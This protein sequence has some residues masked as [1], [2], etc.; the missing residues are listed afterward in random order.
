VGLLKPKASKYT[1]PEPAD[2]YLMNPLLIPTC[3]SITFLI[4]TC[5]SVTFLI[6]TCRTYL[7]NPFLS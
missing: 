4:P 5:R 7:I 2:H 1:Q 3:R 6:S